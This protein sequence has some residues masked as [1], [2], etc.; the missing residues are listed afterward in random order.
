MRWIGAVALVVVSVAPG[1]AEL[2]CTPTLQCPT[3]AVV[4]A[5]RGIVERECPC[6]AQASRK[7]YKQCAKQA[8]RTAAQEI[9][10]ALT[11]DCQKDVKAASTTRPAGAPGSSRA[12][13]GTGR[14]PGPAAGS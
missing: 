13:S 11:A 5:A 14:T 4:D 2:V 12:T 8:L 1:G 9:G 6:A 7:A 3:P 10:A